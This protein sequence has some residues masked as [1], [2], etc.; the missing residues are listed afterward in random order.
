MADCT[1]GAVARDD[2]QIG[3][4]V[5]D[6][7]PSGVGITVI[8]GPLEGVEHQDRVVVHLGVGAV[9]QAYP[10]VRKLTVI[11]I[12]I[13]HVVAN[14]ATGVST[15]VQTEADTTVTIDDGV[16][17]DEVVR[18][19]YVPEVNG[20]FRDG[21]VRTDDVPKR[22]APDDP[23][24]SAVRVDATYVVLWSDSRGILKH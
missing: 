5:F 20:K 9:G 18:R 22:V 10:R 13:D 15:A 7:D 8:D 1:G 4:V 19:R 24:L 2:R 14:D 6:E 17:L 21:G 3:G 12:M 16:L 23:V 11:G